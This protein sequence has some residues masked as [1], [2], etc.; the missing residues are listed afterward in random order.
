[1]LWSFTGIFFLEDTDIIRNKLKEIGLQYLKLFDLCSI[2]C[3]IIQENMNDI[4]IL[5]NFLEIC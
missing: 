4:S 1:M 5:W 3:L 2:R